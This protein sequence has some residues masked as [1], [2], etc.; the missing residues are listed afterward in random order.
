MDQREARRIRISR[1]SR[2]IELRKS[3]G[4]E[5][6]PATLFFGSWIKKARSKRPCLL[7]PE[8]HLSRHFERTARSTKPRCADWCDDKLMRAST[9]SFLAER[10][11]RVRR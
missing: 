8:L 3:S 1:D 10:P 4:G 11:A 2:R 5:S 9:S 7:G 6:L